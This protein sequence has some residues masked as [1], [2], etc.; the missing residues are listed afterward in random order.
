MA[1]KQGGDQPEGM[2]PLYYSGAFIIVLT[3]IWYNYHA[4]IT[5]F[6][7][8]VRHSE[9]M[10][11]LFIA[12]GI[13]FCLEQLTMPQIDLSMLLQDIADHS[14]Q[15]PAQLHYS[16]LWWFLSKSG[17]YL[18]PFDVA[19]AAACS[20]HLIFRNKIV[21][22]RNVYSM[23]L[24]RKK[25]QSNWPHTRAASVKN[26]VKVPI[27]DPFWGMSEQ[28]LAFAKKN[29]LLRRVIRDRR[30]AVEVDHDKA[31]EVFALQL[32]R[33]WTGLECLKDY[34]LALFAV[35]AA[36]ANRASEDA[37]KMIRQL[38]KSGDKGREGLDMSGVKQLLQAH[39]QCKEVG[40]AVSPHAYVYTVMASMLE[41]ARTDGVIASSEFLWLKT[42]DRPL[43]YVLNTVGRV[44]A[45]PEIAGIISHWKIE[46]K[47]RRPLKV[48]FVAEA[49]KALDEAILEILYN[50]DEPD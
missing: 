14:A 5:G 1:G 28:P 4:Q 40:L 2:E 29:N 30:P 34:E 48:P 44:T 26:L 46:A 22:F 27:D 15:D 21:G 13:N 32:G 49:V 11:V 18:A 38:A 45:F 12:D 25:E 39:V 42:V 35:F 23:H 16:D 37:D 19:L 47:L 6:F 24:L 33:M 10:A 20:Y 43:W 7:I 3:Y 50:P 31:E 9:L 36:K 17:I 41:M 8:S